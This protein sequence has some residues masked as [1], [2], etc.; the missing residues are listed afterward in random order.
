MILAGVVWDKLS[1]PDRSKLLRIAYPERTEYLINFEAKL[2][3]QKL[4]PSTQQ[5]VSDVDFNSVLGRDVT[6]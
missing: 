2:R 4:L 3:W 5:D 6:P 1:K